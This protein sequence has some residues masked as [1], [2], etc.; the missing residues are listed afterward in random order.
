MDCTQTYRRRSHATNFLLARSASCI[1]SRLDSQLTFATTLSA[2][3]HVDLR[4]NN[5]HDPGMLDLLFL[6][7]R[8]L[9]LGCRGHHEL[10]LE[11]LA[12][13]SS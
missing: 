5:H 9:A 1:F 11:N 12:L 3:V 8:A 2:S 10:V 13:G 6:I 4:T 7:G